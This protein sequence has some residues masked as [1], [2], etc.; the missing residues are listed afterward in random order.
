MTVAS[1][2]IQINV[3]LQ[4]TSAPGTFSSG[5][6]SMTNGS[7]R[8]FA[9]LAFAI[10]G[11]VSA[12]LASAAADPSTATG[13]LTTHS[14]PNMSAAAVTSA[15][16]T[17]ALTNF[18][19]VT[20]TAPLYTGVGGIL[21]PNFWLDS[22]PGVGTVVYFDPAKLT[23]LPNGEFVGT[24]NNFTAVVQF[25]DGTSWATGL[26]VFTPLMVGYLDVFTAATGV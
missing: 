15:A 19:T 10:P 20:L 26:V 17:S 6:A 23:V 5:W 25:F 1:A 7:A 12:A 13:D 22:K 21:D 11:T 9:A 4:T 18:S 3:A 24:S 16:V 14:G 2:D 8:G